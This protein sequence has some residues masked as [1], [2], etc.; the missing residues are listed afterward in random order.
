MSEHGHDIVLKTIIVVH[1]SVCW[2][3]VICCIGLF[4]VKNKFNCIFDYS[5][6][7]RLFVKSDASNHPV[8][9]AGMVPCLFIWRLGRQKVN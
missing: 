7:C 2:V 1:M 5:C 3:Y 6:S 9:R 4:N 8:L